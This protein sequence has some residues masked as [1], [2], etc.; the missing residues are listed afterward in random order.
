MFKINNVLHQIINFF[1]K[2][3][4]LSEIE[5]KKVWKTFWVITVLVYAFFFS[6]LFLKA[7]LEFS[8]WTISDWLINYEDG[9]FKRRGLSGSFLFAIQDAVSI[10]LKSQI[11]FIQIISYI[12]FLWI[13]YKNIKKRQ[14]DLFL[15]GILLSPFVLLYPICTIGN[16]GRKEILLII[17][18]YWYAFADNRKLYDWITLISYLGIIFMHEL[19]FFYLPFLIWIKYKKNNNS[20]DRFFSIAAILLSFLSVTIIFNYG[21]N[22]NQ[23]KSIPMLLE[24]G[25]K[26]S[27]GNIFSQEFAYD[28]NHV[29][30][31]R[32]SFAVHLLELILIM[33][34]ML[35]YAYY[36]QQKHFR[37]YF[38]GFTISFFWALPL[39]YLAIDWFRW[40]YIYSVFLSLI[41]LL[42]TA[43]KETFKINTKGIKVWHLLLTPL[44]FVLFYFH[45]NHD[46]IFQRLNL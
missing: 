9:G 2:E 1:L 28:F 34:Q 11:F 17:L 27:P 12:S 15:I 33:S 31:Y 20:Y 45:M 14:L 10:P 38:F 5:E 42:Q 18:F 46:E 25:I 13:I 29:L 22:I 39:Y 4:N 41:I 3:V 23:G 8:Q 7:K 30:R 24:R 21:G 32:L 37:E 26:L 40:I 43:K 19:A 44:L 35:Y 36:F 6:L 16:A